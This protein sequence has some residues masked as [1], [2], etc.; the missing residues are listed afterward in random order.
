MGLVHG[1]VPMSSILHYLSQW[2]LWTCVSTQRWWY[3]GVA[4]R[5]TASFV[6]GLLAA[7]LGRVL[8]QS[9]DHHPNKDVELEDDSHPTL[10]PNTQFE[11]ICI[12]LNYN[13]SKTH[14]RLVGVNFIQL[15]P[16]HTSRQPL[17]TNGSLVKLGLQNND[18]LNAVVLEAQL[19]TTSSAFALY[20]WCPEGHRVITWGN[21]EEGGDSSKVQ[22]QLSHLVKTQKTTRSWFLFF[23][24]GGGEGIK[25]SRIPNPGHKCQAGI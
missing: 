15:Q 14:L 3:I 24:W 10:Q 9:L 22:E 17:P 16:Y 19:A 20:L 23:F 13:I 1:L 18:E 25:K 12:V 7:V 21:E 2:S 11:S 4:H 8:W 6:A 5:G